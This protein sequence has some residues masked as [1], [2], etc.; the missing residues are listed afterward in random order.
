MKVLPSVAARSPGREEGR[1][2]LPSSKW[3]GLLCGEEEWSLGRKEALLDLCPVPRSRPRGQWC[4]AFFS[5]SSAPLPTLTTGS[6]W[7]QRTV[8]PLI[9][10]E[11]HPKCFRSRSMCLLPFLGF[12]LDNFFT[13]SSNSPIQ[14]SVSSSLLLK[15]SIVLS[16]L[17]HS[18]FALDSYSC[19]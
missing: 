5:D 7:S 9:H 19:W 12:P 4:K 11:T 18:S 10:K 1:Q 14:S 2:V 16:Q 17:C 15:P 13:L 6:P 8:L 3:A